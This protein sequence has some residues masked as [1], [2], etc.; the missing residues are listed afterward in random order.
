M[1]ILTMCQ[2]GDHRSV[3]VASILRNE[4]KQRDVISCGAYTFSQE[5]L[6]MLYDWADKIIVTT[7]EVLE[8]V[9]PEYQDKVIL[10]DLGP[11]PYG[12]NFHPPF[13]DKARQLL[14][15]NGL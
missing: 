12:P 4:R 10:V 5:T 14:T 11:D 8:S 6:V 9:H 3:L 15:E 2:R 7:R 13:K 1:N